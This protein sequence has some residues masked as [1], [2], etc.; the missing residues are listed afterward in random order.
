MLTYY[1]TESGFAGGK[2]F[3]RSGKASVVFIKEDGAWRA[4]HEHR[5]ANQ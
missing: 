3:K 2:E 4:I 5:S 1:F